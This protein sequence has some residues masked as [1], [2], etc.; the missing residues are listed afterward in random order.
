MKTLESQVHFRTLESI[1]CDRRCSQTCYKKRRKRQVPTL[2]CFLVVISV[3]ICHYSL[4][5]SLLMEF[6]E[7]RQ[8]MKRKLFETGKITHHMNMVSRHCFC[9]IWQ[10]LLVSVA[11]ITGRQK[12]S[13]KIFNFSDFFN[14][15]IILLSLN[16]LTTN[17]NNYAAEQND[18]FRG[19]Y[20]FVVE[21]L[22]KS[23]EWQLAFPFW[24]SLFPFMTDLSIVIKYN[25]K[26]EFWK[27]IIFS[28]SW[29]D[30]LYHLCI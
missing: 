15:F 18:S 1:P 4:L 16:K 11:P 22:H 21:T 8:K 10:T 14:R 20:T 28:F 26:E 13:T 2:T 12:V 25:Y 7:K 9:N 17:K 30:W 23:P 24:T 29:S 5:L 6:Q 27:N 3:K 19:T